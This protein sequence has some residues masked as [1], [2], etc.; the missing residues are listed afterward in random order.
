MPTAYEKYKMRN[1]A[2]IS[3]FIQPRNIEEE[4][5]EYIAPESLFER[6]QNKIKNYFEAKRAREK[7]EAIA[8]ITILAEQYKLR[9]YTE[10]T[11]EAYA[12]DDANRINEGK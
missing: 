2:D 10:K 8:L 5:S 9:R 11:L 12:K 7:A 1:A 4:Y 3:P 6:I